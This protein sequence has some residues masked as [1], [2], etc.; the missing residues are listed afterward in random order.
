[1]GTEVAEVDQALVAKVIQRPGV[2]VNEKS[3]R[4]VPD[5]VE[6]C[7]ESHPLFFH[8]YDTNCK[9][10]FNGQ[11]VRGVSAQHIQCPDCGYEKG[12]IGGDVQAC[13]GYWN[14][15][16]NDEIRNTSNDKEDK[17]RTEHRLTG[18]G[19]WHGVGDMPAYELREGSSDP[20]Y[21]PPACYV[22]TYSRRHYTQEQ[23]VALQ[24][25]NKATRER[26]KVRK[27]KKVAVAAG[28]DALHDAAE[29]IAL[30]V[31]MFNVLNP[32]SQKALRAALKQVKEAKDMPNG[33]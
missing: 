29:G 11:P 26:A 12:C 10:G 33:T 15:S 24:A 19:V 13:A 23:V 17:P 2:E 8:I 4:L 30:N 14:D 3:V 21:Y 5:G 22:S 7:C 6:I 18:G 25:K 16:F 9:R 27:A 1:M 20:K 32:D 28:W 31:P